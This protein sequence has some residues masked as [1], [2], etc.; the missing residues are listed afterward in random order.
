MWETNPMREGLKHCMPRETSLQGCHMIPRQQLPISSHM[1]GN[2]IKIS[3][4]D[5]MR[6]SPKCWECHVATFGD[7]NIEGLFQRVQYHPMF[8]IE[9]EKKLFAYRLT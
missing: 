3:K 9:E 2:L 6:C 5:P 7:W 4:S 1:E 8:Q